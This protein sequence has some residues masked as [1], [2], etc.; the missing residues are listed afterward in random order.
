[1]YL[2]MC[3]H[4]HTHIYIYNDIFLLKPLNTIKIS[5]AA[6]IPHFGGLR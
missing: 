1:M 2:C 5:S 3:V 6:Y 4:T